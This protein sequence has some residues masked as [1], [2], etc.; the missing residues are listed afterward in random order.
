MYRSKSEC[1]H[2]F[3]DSVDDERECDVDSYSH[4]AY[5]YWTE[6]NQDGENQKYDTAEECESVSF[7]LE[8]LEVAGVAYRHETLIKHPHP[9]DE[10]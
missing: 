1:R 10:R 4:H 2:Y 5:R 7:N 8:S 6:Q 9:E 3:R